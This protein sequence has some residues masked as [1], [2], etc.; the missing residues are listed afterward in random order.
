MILTP[1]QKAEELYNLCFLLHESTID[2][3]GA[4]QVVALNKVLAKKS[5]II[6]VDEILN[7]NNKIPGNINGLHI[8]ENTEY[9]QEVKKEIEKL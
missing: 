7:N 1:K 6:A 8:I 4:W 5:A 3:N 9:W 2:V